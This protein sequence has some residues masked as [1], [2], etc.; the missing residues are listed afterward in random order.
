MIQ[1]DAEQLLN[2]VF[3]LFFGSVL[4]LLVVYAANRWLGNPFETVGILFDVDGEAN[5]PAWFSSMQLFCIGI[6]FLFLRLVMGK[7]PG[8]RLF[9]AMGIV[10]IFL[11]MDEA[12]VIHEKITGVLKQ[13]SWVPRFKGGRGIWITVYGLIGAWFF[14]AFKEDMLLISRRFARPTML[15]ISGAGIFM[16]GGVVMEVLNYYQVFGTLQGLGPFM[17]EGAEMAGASFM[18]L[19]A[20]SA[21]LEYYYR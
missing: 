20:G 21:L 14:I 12:A 17:E 7:A 13:V 9:K 19:G 15:F 2:R 3:R 4:I 6:A 10:F 8:S 16:L 18:L 11:S 5:I 1:A